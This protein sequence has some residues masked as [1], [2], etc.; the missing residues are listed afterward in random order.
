MNQPFPINAKRQVIFTGHPVTLEETEDS[1]SGWVATGWE[2]GLPVNR[3]P[4]SASEAA[5][6]MAT[7]PHTIR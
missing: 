3:K 1:L 7:Y 6:L 2:Q 4:I 5:R